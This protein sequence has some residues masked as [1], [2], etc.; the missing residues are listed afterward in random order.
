MASEYVWIQPKYGKQMV[1]MYGQVGDGAWSLEV[2]W[3]RVLTFPKTS[4]KFVSSEESITD[5]MNT[6]TTY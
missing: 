6:Q 3:T 1:Y 2:E 5:Y 4:L